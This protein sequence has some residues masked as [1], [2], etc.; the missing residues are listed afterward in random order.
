MCLHFAGFAIN[1]YCSTLCK[2]TMDIKTIH[3]S[4]KIASVCAIKKMKITFSTLC[5]I[6]K[7]NYFKNNKKYFRGKN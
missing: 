7:Y 1:C 5:D 3:I 2:A 6:T 4:G